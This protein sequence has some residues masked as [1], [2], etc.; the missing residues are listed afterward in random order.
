MDNQVIAANPREAMPIV[1]A[2][3]TTSSIKPVP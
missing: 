1:K 2:G 3:A